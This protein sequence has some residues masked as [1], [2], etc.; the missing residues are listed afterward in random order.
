MKIRIN[1]LNLFEKTNGIYFT[2][3][4]NFQY[5][6][7]VLAIADYFPKTIWE[8]RRKRKEFLVLLKFNNDKDN[9]CFR[10]CLDN[11]SI[12]VIDDSINSDWIQTKK[13]IYYSEIDRQ[14]IKYTNLEC[15][16]WMI[17]DKAFLYDII[18]NHKIALEKFKEVSKNLEYAE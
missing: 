4:I 15:P 12:E 2:R 1:D 18:E 13:F 11:D 9:V 8:C 3:D 6:Y 14:E 7:E 17:D 10:W 5:E 16:K